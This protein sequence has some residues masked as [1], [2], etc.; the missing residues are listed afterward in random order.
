MRNHEISKVLRDA[1]I[2]EHRLWDKPRPKWDDYDFIVLECIKR[3]L[4]VPNKKS[5][6]E[7]SIIRKIKRLS[8]GK[9]YESVKLA[10][11]DN[12]M[13]LNLIYDNCNG[14]KEQQKFIYIYEKK[15]QSLA[16]SFEDYGILPQ[17]GCK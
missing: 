10:S 3:G 17:E 4:P 6:S 16:K 15:V 13:G 14:I 7:V 2:K 5:E 12:G 1:G 8:D 11:E 9:V